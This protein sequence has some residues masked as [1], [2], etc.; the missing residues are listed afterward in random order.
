MTEEEKREEEIKGYQQSI[1]KS[2]QANYFE[3]AGLH[4]DIFL[5]LLSTATTQ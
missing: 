1:L 4:I 3:V 5:Q 2:L